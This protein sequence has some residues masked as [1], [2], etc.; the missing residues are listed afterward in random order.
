VFLDRRKGRNKA[1][2]NRIKE[3]KKKI[4]VTE[5]YHEKCEIKYKNSNKRKEKNDIGPKETRGEKKF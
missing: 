3:Q 5:K 4:K 1:S 2:E